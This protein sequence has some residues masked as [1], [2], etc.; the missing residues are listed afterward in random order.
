MNRNKRGI[1]LIEE[2][3]LFTRIQNG[4]EQEQ[5]I[6]LTATHFLFFPPAHS[7]FLP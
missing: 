4:I 2:Q 3:Y 6:T 5:F 7:L 1:I